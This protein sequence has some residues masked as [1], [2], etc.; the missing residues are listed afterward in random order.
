M[1]LASLILFFYLFVFILLFDIE[2][3]KIEFHNC[4]LY[5]IIVVFKK[6]SR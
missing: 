4:F 6:K 3:I 1:G 5:K 2:L